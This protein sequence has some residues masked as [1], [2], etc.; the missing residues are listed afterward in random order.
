MSETNSSF[1]LCDLNQT[2]GD[3]YTHTLEP[4][5]SS[6]RHAHEKQRRIDVRAAHATP[7]VPNVMCFDL[8]P[9]NKGRRLG[10][11]RPRRHPSRKQA[12]MPPSVRFPTSLRLCALLAFLCYLF[13]GASLVLPSE[14]RCARCAKFGAGG[15]VQS[16]VSCPLSYHGH[17]CHNSRRKT[18]GHIILCPDGCLRH[19]GQ[20]GEIPSLAKFLSAISV[21]LPA[22]IPTGPVPQEATFF[23]LAPPLSPLDHPPSLPS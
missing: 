2:T 13:A 6:V 19:N 20:G 15:A 14:L 22:W 8:V 18:A 1:F 10:D 3:S 11:L 9:S 23:L 21:D 17:D 5:Y 16:G 7:S 4:E 12:V